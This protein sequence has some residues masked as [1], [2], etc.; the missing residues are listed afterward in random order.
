MKLIVIEGK[1]NI[2]TTIILFIIDYNIIIV[3]I[4][5]Y[6]INIIILLITSYNLK[7]IIL[8]ITSYL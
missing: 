4:T 8:L 1:G 6:N 7:I 3:L 5:P 2:S